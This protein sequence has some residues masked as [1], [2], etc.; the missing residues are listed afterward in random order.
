MCEWAGV[1]VVSV[2]T[3]LLRDCE[4]LCVCLCV[5]VC[6]CMC[7]RVRVCVNVRVWACVRVSV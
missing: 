6:S 2:Y 1:G 3:R 4:I 7:V 5:Y